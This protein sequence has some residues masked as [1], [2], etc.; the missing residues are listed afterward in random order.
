MIE[1]KKLYS[2]VI[3]SD[4]LSFTYTE[5]AR[6]I[7]NVLKANGVN[8][9][10]E[11]WWNI[12][13]NIKNLIF[14]GSALKQTFNYLWRFDNDTNI[15]FY[16]T[17]EGHPIVRNIDLE[18]VNRDNVKVI[19]VS[20][21]VKQRLEEI[22]VKVHDVIPHAINMDDY[23]VDRGFGEEIRKRIGKDRKILLNISDN[24]ARKGLDNLLVAYKVVNYVLPETFLILHSQV[25]KIGYGG[26]DIQ[27][28]IDILEINNIW[29]TGTMG[30]LTRSKV[31]AFYELSDI[32]I[33][34]SYAEGFG[35]PMIESLRAN[36]PVIA[37]DAK[38]FNEIIKHGET[39][40]LIPVQKLE[41]FNIKDLMRAFMHI[42]AIDDLTDA[43]L[44]LCTSKDL[45]DKLVENIKKDK[46]RFHAPNVYKNF[47][48]YIE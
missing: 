34:S 1:G 12:G 6:E 33:C 17:V 18:A 14:V 44:S 45:Y 26:I 24:N 42:Y 25:G 16:V 5:I 48:K 38:P 19:A 20:E 10:V 27:K 8:N 22:G 3:A 9:I 39:G 28:Y 35:L 21:F 13:S 31:N 29:Y 36:K 43:I 47:L 30:C 4:Y 7:G 41:F 2:T 15:I 40:I 11:H 23:V 32:Y 37:V 46:Y